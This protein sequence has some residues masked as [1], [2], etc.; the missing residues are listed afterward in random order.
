MLLASAAR[1]PREIVSDS[2]R[3]LGLVTTPE[4]LV[5]AFNVFSDPLV[6]RY[7][8]G[9]RVDAQARHDL[10]LIKRIQDHPT[11]AP[12][13]RAHALFRLIE[14]ATLDRVTAAMI[15]ETATG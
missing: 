11:A 9:R 6:A 8:D 12:K 7:L 2:R 13:Q 10:E 5:A 4:K 15:D 1:L 3:T 14:G